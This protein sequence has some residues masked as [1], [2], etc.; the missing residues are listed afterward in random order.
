MKVVDGAGSRIRLRKATGRW[1]AKMILG[2]F[3]F[4]ITTLVSLITIA[5]T[6]NR[7]AI[8]D[9]LAGTEVVR[10]TSPRR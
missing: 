2:Q 3:T 4:G 7:K 5:Q 9:T 6:P 8:H 10:V 1:L